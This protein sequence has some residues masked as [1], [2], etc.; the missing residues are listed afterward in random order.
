MR[1]KLCQKGKAGSF[2]PAW[3]YVN[4]DYK[5]AICSNTLFTSSSPYPQ[6]LFGYI[7]SGLCL[8]PRINSLLMS[9]P[10]MDV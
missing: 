10:V 1:I 9:F 3:R 8:A 2:V 5:D 6:V 7:I 4:C